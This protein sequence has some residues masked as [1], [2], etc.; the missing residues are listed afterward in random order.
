MRRGT[1]DATVNRNNWMNTFDLEV[2]C[3]LCYQRRI[4]LIVVMTKWGSVIVVLCDFV[5]CQ[6]HNGAPDKVISFTSC[7]SSLKIFTT[8]SSNEYFANECWLN[9]C[10]APLFISS[11]EINVLCHLAEHDGS[12]CLLLRKNVRNE[13]IFIHEQWAWAWRMI[14]DSISSLRQMCQECFWMCACV[15]ALLLLYIRLRTLLAS[16]IYKTAKL[17]QIHLLLWVYD[18]F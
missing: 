7:S 1:N 5:T 4:V 18:Y 11:T 9:S 6:H 14:Y 10:D 16:H 17:T 2:Y 3:T 15:L 8:N 13:A 12:D